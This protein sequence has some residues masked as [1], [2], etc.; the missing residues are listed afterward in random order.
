MTLH[1]SDILHA[2]IDYINELLDERSALLARLHGARTTL[3]PG[4]PA[5]IVPPRKRMVQDINN[6]PPGQE[7]DDEGP[8]WEREWQGGLGKL[9]D[10]GD[11][12]VMDEGDESS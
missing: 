12:A 6:I 10:M 2:A 8:L 1:N 4:H 3:P 5:L 9:G 11:G 7:D